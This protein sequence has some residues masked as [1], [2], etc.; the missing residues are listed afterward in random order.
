MTGDCSEIE[1]DLFV[2]DFLK[3]KN[4]YNKINCFLGSCS[5]VFFFELEIAIFVE[6]IV[7]CDLKMNNYYL[8]IYLNAY[9]FCLD[10]EFGSD[11]ESDFDKTEDFKSE[12]G[13]FE[14]EPE[15]FE[16]ELEDF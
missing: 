16:S 6:F 15:D 4:K 5:D 10:F 8:M 12:L 13:D 11:F 9:C 14:S 7:T 2:A 1:T 3:N